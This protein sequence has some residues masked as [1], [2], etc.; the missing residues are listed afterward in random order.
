MWG[1][2]VK[3]NNL[4][5]STYNGSDHRTIE[6]RYFTKAP[7]KRFRR[8]MKE[9]DWKKFRSNL[10]DRL[11]NWIIPRTMTRNDLDDHV[12]FFNKALGDTC[13]E[14]STLHVVKPRDPVINLWFTD[15]L[16]NERKE[17]ASLGRAAVRSGLQNDWDSFHEA[18][19]I[20]SGNLR[21]AARACFQKFAT[22][23]PDLSDMARFCKIVRAQPRHDIGVLTRPDGDFTTSTAWAMV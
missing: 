4:D 1:V 3:D 7:K 15:E 11:R 22:E 16:R 20:Y 10:A 23:L 18:Q 12:R 17:V 14:F 6:S 2:K 21:K 5:G 13:E 19:R 8:S 9:V